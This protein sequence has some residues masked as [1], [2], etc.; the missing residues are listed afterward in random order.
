V[1]ARDGRKPYGT[2]YELCGSTHAEANAAKLAANSADV[3]GAAYL[4]GH[5]DVQGLPRRAP[6][7]ECSHL[8]HRA[9][10][11]D[12]YYNEIETKC[13]AWLRTLIAGR[14][15]APGHVDERQ[16]SMFDLLTLTDIAK[17]ISSQAS[18]AGPRPPVRRLAR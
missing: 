2:G 12:R 5:L 4:T 3:P 16:L 13:A 18:A 1:P 8:P 17:S 15:H 11:R 10:I 7:G 6:G 9:A 14:P